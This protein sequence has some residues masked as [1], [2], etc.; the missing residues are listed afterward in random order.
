MHPPFCEHLLNGCINNREPGIASLKSFNLRAR[1]APWN[2]ASVILKGLVATYFWKRM[3][4]ISIKL[5]PH[6][7]IHPLANTWIARRK[8]K[9]I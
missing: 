9:V 2:I 3:H 6:Q 8:L 1:V 7:L 5:S 4:D